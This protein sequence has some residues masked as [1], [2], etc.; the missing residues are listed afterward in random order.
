MIDYIFFALSKKNFFSVSI[1]SANTLTI[2]WSP[3]GINFTMPNDTFWRKFMLRNTFSEERLM[4][5][6]KNS[7]RP[8]KFLLHLIK[9]N[10]HLNQNIHQ[11]HATLRMLPLMSVHE[12]EKLWVIH[13]LLLLMHTKAHSIIDF[14]TKIFTKNPSQL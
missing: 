13:L 10:F 11:N 6:D 8:F 4:F 14:T 9:L 3:Q 1:S 12:F 7:I 2:D 5:S